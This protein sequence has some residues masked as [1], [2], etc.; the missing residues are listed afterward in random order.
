MY[1]PAWQSTGRRI[2]DNRRCGHSARAERLRT[3]HESRHSAAARTAVLHKGGSGK[4]QGHDRGNRAYSSSRTSFRDHELI[5]ACAVASHV[6]AT[7]QFCY[8]HFMNALLELYKNSDT[9]HHAYLIVSHKID[10]T[11][12]KLKEFFEEILGLRVSGN[13]DFFHQKFQTLSIDDARAISENESRKSLDGKKK[14]FLIE[15]D[16]ITEEAQNSLLKIFEEPALGTHFFI[17]SPQDMLLPTLRSRMQVIEHS[18]EAEE[19]SSILS[20]DLGSRLAQVKEITEGISDEEKTKQDAIAFLNSIEAELYAGG[21]EK[22]AKG[23]EVCKL[24]RKALYDRGAPVKMILEN[25]VL[26]I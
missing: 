3:G 7:A 17:I 8:N 4:E 13:P 6:E 11:A 1:A 10:E 14:I 16:F 15:A 9:L 26:S 22:N 2:P 20:L 18:S 5:T 21:V 25:L 24:T 23:L 19:S 12:E